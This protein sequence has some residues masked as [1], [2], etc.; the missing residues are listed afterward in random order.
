[1]NTQARD[2]PPQLPERPL[3]GDPSFHVPL[4]MHPLAIKPTLKSQLSS[5]PVGATG[6]GGSGTSVGTRAAA[7]HDTYTDLGDCTKP[8]FLA[9]HSASPVLPAHF[10]LTARPSWGP[11]PLHGP[12]AG[13]PQPSPAP[14]SPDSAQSHTVYRRESILFLF[15]KLRS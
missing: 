13:T 8:S 14:P 5:W 11:Q 12:R 15:F 10:A 9:P 6:L 4:S 1:M 7:H 2:T 3:S